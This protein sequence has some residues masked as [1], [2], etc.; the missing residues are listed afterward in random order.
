MCKGTLHRFLESFGRPEGLQ[1]AKA[2]MWGVPRL[3]LALLIPVKAYYSPFLQKRVSRPTVTVR[4]GM[5]W[6]KHPF[7][8]DIIV[9]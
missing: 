3:Q 4:E 1:C 2:V 8:K 5:L 9:E 6:F 7:N